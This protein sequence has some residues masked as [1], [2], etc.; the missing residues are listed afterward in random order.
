MDDKNKLGH[1]ILAHWQTHHPKMV[2]E[3]TRTRRL[4]QVLHEAQEQ[5]GDLLHQLIC[6][7]RMQYQAAWEVAMNLWTFPPDEDRPHLRSSAGSNPNPQKH[8]PA[9]SR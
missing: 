1:T 4:E 8:P 2:A 5:T 6:E 7:Q 3:L 9:T